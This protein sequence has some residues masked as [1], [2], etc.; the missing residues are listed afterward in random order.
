[1]W[2]VWLCDANNGGARASDGVAALG[3]SFQAFVDELA[4]DIDLLGPERGHRRMESGVSAPVAEHTLA[5][6]DIDSAGSFV[7]LDED[8]PRARCLAL[9]LVVA[10]GVNGP[11][12]RLPHVAELAVYAF[13]VLPFLI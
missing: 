6:L 4:R 8:G 5:G 3:L 2:G 1:M 9:A 7:A 12:N 10:V 11:A 13:H